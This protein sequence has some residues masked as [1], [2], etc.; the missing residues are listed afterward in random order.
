MK[1]QRLVFVEENVALFVAGDG[2]RRGQGQ[3]ARGADGG[4]FGLDGF[5]DDLVREFAAEA[6]E[7]GAVGAVAV[8][9]EGE[10]AV[11]MGFDTR[12]LREQARLAEPAG[13]R[14]GCAH[15][16]DGVG[17]G[18]SDADFEDLKEAGSHRKSV[19]DC[20]A[21]GSHHPNEG[22]PAD[23]SRRG[24]L[25]AEQGHEAEVHVQLLVAVEE[26]EAGIVGDKIDFDLVVTADHHHVFP[27]AGERDAGVF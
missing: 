9:G 16:S 20:D 1:G 4:E 8:S 2:M 21:T 13:E 19:T 22:F 10:R 26:R 17:T 3:F 24:S 11:E 14:R 15:R 6:Q 23:G 25:I 5:G 7:D 18:G 12:G 27:H